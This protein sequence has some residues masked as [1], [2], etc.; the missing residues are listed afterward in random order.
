MKKNIAFMIVD[1]NRVRYNKA[2]HHNTLKFDLNDPEQFE[3]ARRLAFGIIEQM[4]SHMNTFAK[5]IHD[6]E[7]G[8]E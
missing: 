2:L 8:E 6:K 1:G 3:Q 7:E 5:E 4:E